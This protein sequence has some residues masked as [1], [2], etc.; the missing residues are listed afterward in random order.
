MLTFTDDLPGTVI[1]G[2]GPAV[3]RTIAASWVPSNPHQVMVGF[4]DRIVWVSRD[5]WLRG[6]EAPYCEGLRQYY[7]VQCGD[8]HWTVVRSQIPGLPVLRWFVQT[9]RVTA[10]I[11]DTHLEVP[12]SWADDLADLADDAKLEAWLAAAS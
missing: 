8:V 2:D 7:P 4:D 9:W 11:S 12:T 6:N 5:G 1:L 3:G 10:F